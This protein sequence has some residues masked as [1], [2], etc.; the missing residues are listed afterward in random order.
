MNLQLEDWQWADP[1]WLWLSLLLPFL[2]L[3]RARRRPPN[4]AFGPFVLLQALPRSS[5]QRWRF[6]PTS[7][8]AVAFLLLIAAAARP[9]QRMRQPVERMAA[10]F[11]LCLDTSSSMATR[12]EPSDDDV[13]RFTYA[14][15]AAQTFLEAR[16]ED[17]IGLVS[18]ARDAELTCPPTFDHRSVNT[19]LEEQQVVEEGSPRDATGIGMAVAR[20]ALH[21]KDG[22]SASRVVILLTDGE[23]TVATTG[24]SAGIRPQEA[25]A[26]CR[27]WGVRLHA[28]ATGPQ[29][30]VIRPRL[31]ELA[32]PTGGQAFAAMEGR[33]LDE[34]YLAI[35]QLERT[36]FERLPWRQVD[37]FPV[38]L[39]V[40]LAA[41]LL[42]LA[43]RRLFREV[44]P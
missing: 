28:I 5:R 10:D 34:V 30:S 29:A 8:Q 25:A 3:L 9:Q 12:D 24:S 36:R 42:A 44:R 38:V 35:D 16:P 27:Q 43:M 22:P 18:F 23:E 40:A 7:L 13:S 6:L 21:L 4:R 19:L 31:E 17:R 32:R 41:W 2:F 39:V 20:A 15:R 26:L 1:A 37:R 14:R 11:L 33:S